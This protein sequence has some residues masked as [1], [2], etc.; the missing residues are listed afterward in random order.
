MARVRAAGLLVHEGRLE[1][2]ELPGS[3]YDLVFLVQTIEHIENP[4]ETLTAVRALLRPGGKAV[5]VTDNARS[6]DSRLFRGRHWGGYHF[7][8]HW[9]LF[10]RDA[11]SALANKVGLDVVRICTQV[12]PVNWVYSIS[13]L[14]V[15]W[16]AP[17]WIYNR[18]SLQSP[19]A[20]GVF[21][22]LD[23]CL[24]TVGKGGLLRA[25]LRRP[26]SAIET[27]DSR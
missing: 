27:T 3:A 8:R 23:S 14:L 15:D 13:N 24:R 21:T 25:V 12:T 16:G 5:I 26:M 19:F 1:E 7:P 22:V 2:L 9:N 10:N 20:L 6:L 11:M 17:R 18:F 4:V